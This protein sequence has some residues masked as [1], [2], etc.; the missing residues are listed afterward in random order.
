MLLFAH[1]TFHWE[2]GNVTSSNALVH[3]YEYAYEY[4]IDYEYD[5]YDYNKIR[6]NECIE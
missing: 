1:Q 2:Y 6:R 5:I 3:L 4:D